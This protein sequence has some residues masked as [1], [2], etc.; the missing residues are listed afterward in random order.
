[1]NECTVQIVL[2]AKIRILQLQIFCCLRFMPEL[3]QKPEF[4][5]IIFNSSMGDSSPNSLL[6]VIT[7]IEN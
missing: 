1:M 7:K 3:Q 5:L 4:I 6:S 2:N